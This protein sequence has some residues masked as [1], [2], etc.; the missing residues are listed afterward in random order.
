[1]NYK[2]I[3]TIIVI[4]A[5]TLRLWNLNSFPAGFNADEASLGYNAYSLINTGKDEYGTSWPLIFKS[6]GDYKPGLLVYVIIPFVKIFGL[7]EWVVRLPSA[8]FGIGTVLLIFFIARKLFQSREIGL[9]AALL[10]AISPWAIHFSRGAFETNAATFFISL[11]FYFLLKSFSKFSFLFWSLISFC[12]SMYVYQ[13]PRLI[14]PL[15]LLVAAFFYRKSLKIRRVKLNLQI[16]TYIVILIFL[17]VPLS[18]QFLSGQASSRFQGLSFLADSGPSSRTDQLRGEEADPDSIWVRIL[19]NKLTA[20][21]SVFLGHYLD[22]FRP[23]FL[24]IRGEEVMRNKVPETGEFYLIESIFLL[25]GLV[26]LVKRKYEHTKLLL[27]WLLI[28]PA[29]S[30]LTF[31]TP[32]ALR[33]LNMVVPMHLVMALGLW[34]IVSLKNRWRGI[35]ILAIS[36]MISFEFLHYLESYYIHYSKRYPLAFE[37]GFSQMV[38]KLNTMESAYKKVVITDRYDQPYILVLFYKKYEPSQYQPQAKLT[39]RDK[40]N[41]GTVRSF[42][43]YEFRQIKSDEVNKSLDTLF[44]GTDQ[45]IPKDA[46]ILD[47]V[48]FPNGEPAFIFAKGD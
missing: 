12:A 35:L 22:H 21:G 25:F 14:V 38:G 36:L 45:E 27:V 32:S 18:L 6:F 48:D 37:Y 39:E 34:T 4:L 42:D 41:F 1:M 11:G 31:Q 40:F 10:L 17:T 47:R 23:D 28:A 43:K 44:I 46:T 30:S 15:F 5:A 8:L 24:F 19:H 3:L 20:Y 2:W 16:L 33:S 9:I 7:V 26:T 13:S 29:A